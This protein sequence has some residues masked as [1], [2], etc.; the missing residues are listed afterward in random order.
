M[1]DEKDRLITINGAYL[2][3]IHLYTAAR[4]L[5]TALATGLNPLELFA[6]QIMFQGSRLCGSGTHNKMPDD[7]SS[8][9]QMFRNAARSKATS[10]TTS[11]KATGLESL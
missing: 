6:I 5:P 9:I 3:A 10:R 2:P 4:Y 7:V 1:V 8:I 11:S